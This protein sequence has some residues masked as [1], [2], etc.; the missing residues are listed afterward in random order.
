[1]KTG[2]CTPAILVSCACIKLV[3]SAVFD[4]EVVKDEL[5]K[6]LARFKVPSC[7]LIYEEFPMLGSG[8]IDAVTLKKDAIERLE[9]SACV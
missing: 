3:S 1:M 4:E 8:K 2:G 6:H 5:L 7:F 9:Q